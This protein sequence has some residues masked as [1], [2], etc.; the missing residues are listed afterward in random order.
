MNISLTKGGRCWPAVT[1]TELESLSLTKKM[2]I[3]DPYFLSGA[4]EPSGLILGVL[5]GGLGSDDLT[6]DKGLDIL[7]EWR[8]PESKCSPSGRSRAPDFIKT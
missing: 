4:D 7:N 5:F 3:G 8:K 6:G 2:F 1:N